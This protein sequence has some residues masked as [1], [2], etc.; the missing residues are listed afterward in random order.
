[1]PSSLNPSTRESY[2]MK[3]SELH[4]GPKQGNWGHQQGLL[5]SC[6]D[7][8]SIQ[9]LPAASLQQQQ[10]KAVTPFKTV[11]CEKRQPG[12]GGRE[13]M[14]DIRALICLNF[15]LPSC[16]AEALINPQTQQSDSVVEELSKPRY[17]HRS[18]SPQRSC[19]LRHF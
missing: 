18:Y 1:M 4:G 15:A 3:W 14:R 11:L 17:L 7:Q 10:E 6:S 19:C 12:R 16:L 13:R 5:L 8:R 9:L 2:T